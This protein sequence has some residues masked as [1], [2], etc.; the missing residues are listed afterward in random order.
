MEPKIEK[1]EKEHSER[2]QAKNGGYPA[3]E[4][5]D[6]DAISFAE[7]PEFWGKLICGFIV[8]PRVE[9]KQMFVEITEG[10]N[11]FVS[12]EIIKLD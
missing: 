3:R 6:S 8:D 4:I 12:K 2:T 1:S 11:T 9:G 5:S 10:K 7:C